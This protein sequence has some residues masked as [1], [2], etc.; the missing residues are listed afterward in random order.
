M[1]AAPLTLPRPAGGPSLSPVGRGKKKHAQH[2]RPWMTSEIRILR[3]HYPAGGRVACARLLD[4]SPAAIATRA[5]EEGI[6]RRAASGASSAWTVTE[7]AAL[8]RLYPAGGT[9]ACLAELP[10]RTRG[11][12][13]ENARRLGL[14]RSGAAHGAWS[15]EEI[16]VLRQHYPEG[17]PR[18]CAA[19]LPARS[20]RAIGEAAKRAGLRRVK[21]GAPLPAPAPAGVKP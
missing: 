1:D 2:Y 19:R 4:R 12:I 8:R 13:R 14:K 6:A 10:G 20:A 11:A 15:A 18:A 16:A 21:A 7:I 5:R 3:Q 17:G 9:V